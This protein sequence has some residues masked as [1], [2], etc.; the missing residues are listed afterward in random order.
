MVG[1]T[2]LVDNHT[3]VPFKWVGRLVLDKQTQLSF[4]ETVYN[5]IIFYI[6]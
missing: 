5:E 2:V 3:S 6:F 1:Q 4:V